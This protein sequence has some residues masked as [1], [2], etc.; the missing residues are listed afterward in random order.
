MPKINEYLPGTRASG[1]V[2][3]P[4]A[5]ADDFGGGGKGLMAVGQAV[6]GVGEL[7]QKRQEQTEVSDLT[8][9]MSQAH[10]EWTANV[11][12]KMRTAK[13]GDATLVEGF[14]NDYDAYM[15][16][17]SEGIS[18]PA[19]RNYFNESSTRLRTHFIESVVTGQAQLAGVKAKEDYTNSINNW[20]SSLT[21]D[22]SSFALTNEMHDKYLDTAVQSGGMS[23]EVAMQLRTRGRT[24]LAKSSVQGWIKLNPELAKQEL[25]DGKWNE[26]IDGDLKNQ[27][28]G[29]ADTQLRANR[30]EDDRL[31]QAQ[32]EELQLQQTETQNAFLNKM[33]K[34]KLTTKEI[35]ASNLEPTGSGSKKQFLDMIE[36]NNKSR[37]LKTDSGTM[38]ALMERIH[39]PD[40]DPRKI[41][42]ENEL[43][44]YFGKGLNM[45]SLGQLRGEIS[46]TKTESG[47]IESDLKNGIMQIAKGQLT[48]TNAM[49]GFADPTGDENLQRFTSFF[50]QTYAEQRKAGKT[51]M[52]LLNP[53]S[54]DYLGKYVS[55]FKKTP[56]EMM[57][58]IFEQNKKR[59]LIPLPVV[60]TPD[61]KTPKA[62]P[63][64]AAGGK[65]TFRKRNP[66]ENAAQYLQEKKKFDAG[67]S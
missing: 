19:G 14:Q 26:F 31:K 37:V 10:A 24:E 48:K 53:D 23:S 43:L 12:E 66:N 36:E 28:F 6:S 42:D 40:T 51:S 20:S 8:V 55:N 11:Q 67:N 18:T 39:L 54:P 59:P 17:V 46:G 4:K 50:L 29:E 32:K 56:Q 16:K 44:Q 62:T 25:K 15:E 30:L 45:E 65:P 41:R 52:E 61:G 9:K 7:M 27:L 13:P 21:N 60:Q 63:P 2:D 22:P 5:T 64:A 35:L 58:A 38:I 1:P 57:R 47:R 34:G 3:R 33:S 49:T